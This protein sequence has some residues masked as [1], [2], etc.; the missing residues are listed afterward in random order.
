[1]LERIK[2]LQEKA[3]TYIERTIDSNATLCKE[4]SSILLDLL[5]VEKKLDKP[6]DTR[7]ISTSEQLESE[8]DELDA[9][10]VARE[11]ML[12]EL[13]EK[14]EVQDTKLLE[15]DRA[16]ASQIAKLEED[17]N[18]KLAE[19]DEVILQQSGDLERLE[20]MIEKG[21]YG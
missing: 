9:V 6:I 17:Y 16:Y 12:D 4:N 13:R 1:M 18:A 2:A 19:K 11:T 15:I 20:K 7:S 5:E 14:L 10:L 3:V 21:R 8:L